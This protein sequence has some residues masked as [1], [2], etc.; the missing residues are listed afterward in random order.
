MACKRIR[1]GNYVSV[2]PEEIN[3]IPRAKEYKVAKKMV[4][5]LEGLLDVSFPQEEI[6]YIAIHLLEQLKWCSPFIERSKANCG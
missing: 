1:H 2:L 3:E 5:R 6:V 4:E